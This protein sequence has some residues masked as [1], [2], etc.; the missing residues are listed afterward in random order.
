MPLQSKIFVFFA[1]LL[2]LIAFEWIFFSI[3]EG[4]VLQEEMSARGSVL[5]R[6]LAQ[7]SAEPVL[8]FQITRLE[9]LID[10]MLEEKD[11]LHARVY[12]SGYTVLAA[13]D[14]E[15]EGWTFSG[16]IVDSQQI[17]YDTELMVAKAP[18]TVMNQTLGMAEIAFSLTTLKAKVSRSRTIFLT[19]FIASCYWPLVSPSSS[20]SRWSGRWESWPERFRRSERIPSTRLSRS[21]HFRQRK[22]IVCGTPWMIRG[23]N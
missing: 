19:I 9:Q 2:L 7:L 17:H 4:R 21:L 1:V 10:S 16:R 22:S 11:V 14:R 23:K 3:F 12:N 18:I 5:V 8:A 13:T 6:T 20:K 15:Q